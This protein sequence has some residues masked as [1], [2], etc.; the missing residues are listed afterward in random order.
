MKKITF[1]I[2]TTGKEKDYLDLLL[3]SMESN[4][5]S[6]EHEVIIFIDSFRL[7]DD[8]NEDIKSWLLSRENKFKNIKILKNKL[9]VPIGYAPNI[10][11][12][13]ES[14]KNDIVSY[15]QSDMIVG[16]NYDVEILRHLKDENTIISATRIEPSLHPQSPEKYTQD[17]GLNPDE[18]NVEDF[19]NF[20]QSN[21]DLEKTTHYWFAPFTLYK[22]RWLEIGGHDTLFR[23]SREDSDILMR[24]RLN[25]CNI[26]Q[27]WS[28]LVYHFTCVSSRGKGWFKKEN[29][30]RTKLQEVADS[31]EM[32]KYLR[33]WKGFEHSAEPI[34][35]DKY[36]YKCSISLKEC[37]LT[38]VEHIINISQFFDKVYIDD[39]ETLNLVIHTMNEKSI[40]ANQ[41]F[42][43]TEEQWNKYSKY[44][45]TYDYNNIF[46]LEPKSDNILITTKAGDINSQERFNFLMQLN[47][48]IHHQTEPN[49]KFEHDIFTIEV[50]EKINSINDNIVVDNP[51][52]KLEDIIEEIE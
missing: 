1:C 45:R 25:G 16:K 29:Q 48:I 47:N 2:N 15:I 44:F 12:M 40:P 52:L 33:K 49:N 14:A 13:F 39:L 23:R 43:Y 41:L 26:I 46:R 17:F 11:L 4:F 36:L 19:N 7:Q 8:D 3:T 18:F 22:Q 38:M 24:L 21:T 31:F 10:N 42:G 30:D 50:G 9:S 51:K 20:V 34:D 32:N 5:V 28:A 37:N 6:L 35:T 27:T